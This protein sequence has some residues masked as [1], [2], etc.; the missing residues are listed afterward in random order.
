MSKGHEENA[1]KSNI[2]KHIKADLKIQKIFSSVQKDK[3]NKSLLCK[4]VASN[5]LLLENV[6][7]FEQI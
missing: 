6:N 7:N 4:Y 2:K 1:Q 5:L 3:L